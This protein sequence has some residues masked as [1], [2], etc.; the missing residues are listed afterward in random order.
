MINWKAHKEIFVE[1]LCERGKLFIRLSKDGKV[2]ALYTCFEET[3]K[4]LPETEE[5]ETIEGMKLRA[6]LHL[7]LLTH[8]EEISNKLK[9]R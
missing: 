7:A 2:N 6:D 3:Q 1:G 5:E 8:A 4:I 9:H